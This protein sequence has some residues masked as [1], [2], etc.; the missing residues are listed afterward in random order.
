MGRH[1]ACDLS[2]ANLLHNVAVIRAQ[3]SRAKI[4]AM[5]KANAYGHGLR[6]VGLRLDAHVDALGVAS[7]EEALALRQAGVKAPIVL[8]EGVFAPEELLCASQHGFH[9]VFHDQSQLQWLKETPLPAPLVAWIKLDTG[10]GRLGF[11]PE[12][13]SPALRLLS[14]SPSIQQPEPLAKLSSP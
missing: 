7:I 13:A 9:V 3:A 11:S 1:T 8:I 4:M 12:A 5:V 2:T 6:S 14:D 10:M